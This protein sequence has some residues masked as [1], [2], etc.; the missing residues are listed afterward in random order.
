MNDEERQAI[1]KTHREKTAQDRRNWDRWLSWYLSETQSEAARLPT[2]AADVEDADATFETN[3]PY[4]W[5]DTMVANVVPQN[6]QNDWHA[7]DEAQEDAG[8]HRAVLSNFLMRYQ[9]LSEMLWNCAAKT[10]LCGRSFIKTTWNFKNQMVEYYP[11]D[12]KH[13]FFD[14]SARRWHDIRY[15]VEATVITEAEFDARTKRKGRQG[16]QVYPSDA[17]KKIKF[18]GYPKWLEQNEE[19]NSLMN[20]A[21]RKVYKWITVY[22]FY[23]FTNNKYYHYA[24]GYNEP[25]LE[26]DLP[27]SYLRNPFVVLKFAENQRDLGGLS[28]IQLISSAKERLDE[29]DTLELWY[30]QSSIP[31]TFFDESRL[32]NSSEVIDQYR[33][34]TGPGQ[35]VRVRKSVNDGGTALQQ[36]FFSPAMPALN[37]SFDKMRARAANSISFVLGLPDFARGVGGAELA[38]EAALSDAAMRTR[39]GRRQ[40]V[41]LNVIRDLGKNT[42]A[43]YEEFLTPGK[44][45]Q[46]FDPDTAQVFKITRQS[47]GARDSLEDGSPNLETPGFEVIPVPY[48]PTENDRLVRLQRLEKY[49]PFLMQGNPHVDIAAITRELLDLLGLKKSF[50]A[51]PQPV[52]GAP[53]SNPEGGPVG[54]VPGGASTEDT[55]VGGGLP[56]G[57]EPPGS[58]GILRGDG[59]EGPMME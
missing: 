49:L 39:N 37:P 24:E 41:I 16:A 40:R 4:A 12:A 5:I 45:I 43:L 2:G 29:L 31:I 18:G 13:I 52:P 30:A 17:K 47:I 35:M 7:F 9:N 20:K 38:T 8:R 53:G 3:Y 32:E 55:M 1:I 15:I 26:D 10:S 42:I 36:M 56:M 19:N 34:A 54:G 44:T 14:M 48:S 59:D 27:Y 6:P 25:L 23:D 46:I 22:E 51:Q 57:L 58:P 33:D 28:D 21:S 11:I 50:V